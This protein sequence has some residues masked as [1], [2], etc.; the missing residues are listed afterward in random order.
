[1]AQETRGC[2]RYLP[3][4]FWKL[5]P[6]IDGLTDTVDDLCRIIDVAERV[7]ENVSLRC[8]LAARRPGLGY[9]CRKVAPAT[10]TLN[11][12]GGLP[13]IAQLPM[14]FWASIGRIEYW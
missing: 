14:P 1:M 3:L 9:G 13:S 7:R 2:R 10:T 12:A 5:P 6:R 4:A 11:Y 8:A